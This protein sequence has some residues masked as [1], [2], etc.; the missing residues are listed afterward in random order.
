MPWQRLVSLL[1]DFFF[2]FFFLPRKLVGKCCLT[3]LEIIK[4]MGGSAL[5]FHLKISML[6]WDS[7]V[8]ACVCRQWS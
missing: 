8:L 3:V 2:F 4:F 1:H 7:N 5:Q 6:N